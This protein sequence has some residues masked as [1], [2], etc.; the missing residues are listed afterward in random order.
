MRTATISMLGVEVH[1][2]KLGILGITTVLLAILFWVI[3][4]TSLG[5]NI[6]AVAD[7][8]VNAALLGINVKAVNQQTFVISSVLAGIAGLLLAV[9]TGIASPDIGLTFGLK[10]L[11]IMT[12]G[13]MGNLLGAV[14]GGLLLGIVE[15]L[16]VQFGLGGYGEIVVWV[17]MIAVL[18]VR[19]DGLLAA[20]GVTEKRA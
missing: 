20:R 8:P 5:R 2:I 4:Y 16:A 15:A 12:I 1:L 17:L 6:S 13:G 9:R 7:S 10:A 18:L 14:V 11:A 19:P 3:K